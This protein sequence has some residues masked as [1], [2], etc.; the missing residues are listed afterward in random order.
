VGQLYRAFVRLD[1]RACASGARRRQRSW[2][3]R[4]PIRKPLGILDDV[5]V[6][7]A[8]L[9]VLFRRRC[10]ARSK[11]SWRAATPIRRAATMPRATGVPEPVRRWQEA[12]HAGKELRSRARQF[13]A[14]AGAERSAHWNNA[15]QLAGA[16][17]VRDF[18]GDPAEIGRAEIPGGLAV[19]GF[20]LPWPKRGPRTE[21]A[22]RPR[23]KELGG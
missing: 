20:G 2:S 22:G 7:L 14:D 15:P 5:I 1:R 21:S 13:G 4:L 12:V 3:P 16:D 6:R 19:P 11:S 9:P 17:G 23:K 18:A 10:A 8:G